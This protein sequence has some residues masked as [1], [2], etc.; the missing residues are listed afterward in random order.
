MTR[1]SMTVGAGMAGGMRIARSVTEVA[2]RM[3]KIAVG[4]RMGCVTVARLGVV[5]GG[6]GRS[7]IVP[8]MVGIGGGVLV[9]V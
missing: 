8:G 2:H 1:G 7:P 3:R 9:V 6:V 5:V 4:G